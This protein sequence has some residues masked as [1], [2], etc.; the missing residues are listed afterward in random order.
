MS[1]GKLLVALSACA[2]LACGAPQQ[3]SNYTIATLVLPEGH[4]D[5]GRDAFV[6]LGCAACHAVA[7]DPALPAPVSAHPGPILDH[8]LRQLPAGGV[9]TAIIVPSHVAAAGFRDPA[10]GL[11]PMGD[12]NESLTVRQLVD[13]VAFLRGNEPAPTQASL[14]AVG[15]L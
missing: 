5:A 4:P 3:E 14:D 10:D 7:W 13:L 11:S 15:H 8:S 12:Y 2:V 1:T 9:A 6:A